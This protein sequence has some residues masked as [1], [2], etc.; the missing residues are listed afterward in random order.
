MMRLSLP[1]A[2]QRYL[3]VDRTM[4]ALPRS[5]VTLTLLS[6]QSVSWGCEMTLRAAHDDA[7]PDASRVCVVSLFLSRCGQTGT[8]ACFSIGARYQPGAAHQKGAVS[9]I[10]APCWNPRGRR[11]VRVKAF[12]TRRS[13]P[14]W[15][16]HTI[17]NRTPSPG[18]THK[19]KR[20]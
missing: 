14:C 3:R 9:T 19:E 8:A 5:A 1:P 18:G 11:P 6:C 4:P 2:P 7:R 12:L 17:E 13:V 20:Q 10:T 16:L 15:F